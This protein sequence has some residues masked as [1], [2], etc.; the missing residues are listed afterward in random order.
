MKVATCFLA[1]F[2][3]VL[4][5]C[6]PTVSQSGREQPAHASAT[7]Y[8]SAEPSRDELL[9]PD[10]DWQKKYKSHAHLTAASL[11]FARWKKID[12][13]SHAWCVGFD[14]PDCEETY[15]ESDY[16]EETA[17]NVDP[18]CWDSMSGRTWDRTCSGYLI[19]Y[20]E[21][22]EAEPTW[23][24]GGRP[25]MATYTADGHWECPEGFGEHS[26]SGVSWAIG[27]QPPV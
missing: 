16:L 23:K 11:Q 7:V 21:V 3:V 12:P 14:S 13:S 26:W 27:Q 10:G 2:S 1:V 17:S 24:Q 15:S 20:S 8:A 9:D 18:A 6:S 19:T 22:E 4:A 25:K 5:G